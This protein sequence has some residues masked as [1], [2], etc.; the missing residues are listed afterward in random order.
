MG[1]IAGVAMEL[2]DGINTFKIA[3]LPEEK[4]KLR[5]GL[6]VGE[7]RQRWIVAVAVGKLCSILWQQCDGNIAKR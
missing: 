4:L 1:E 2:L 5:I 3:H 7:R 6:H